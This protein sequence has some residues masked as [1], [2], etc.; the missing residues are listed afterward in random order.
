M[1]GRQAMT[2]E[3]CVFCEIIAGNAP[4]QMVYRWPDAVAFI[5]L[6]PVVQGHVLVVPTRH[7]KDFGE[8]PETTMRTMAR[9]AELPRKLEPGV[10]WN[11]ITSK[12]KPATQSV[13]HLHVHLVPRRWGDQLM[14]PWGTTGDPHE[15]HWCKVAQRLQDQLA[16][17]TQ[18]A[19]R[20]E[21]AADFTLDAGVV[22]AQ[23]VQRLEARVKELEAEVEL[24]L[25]HI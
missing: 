12:G 25:I 4:A 16:A 6:N 22:Y 8:D 13:F 10:S 11:L 14:L 9:A 2:G 19:Q 17:K 23:E 21:A 5:P 3:P 24:S 18:E 7:V 15:P 1:D 20:M